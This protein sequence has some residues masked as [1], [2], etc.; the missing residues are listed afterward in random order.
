MKCLARKGANRLA[1]AIIPAGDPPKQP[2]GHGMPEMRLQAECVRHAWNTYPQ[3]RLLLF[4]VENEM[5]RPDANAVIGARRRA[6]GIVRGVA[7]LLL[8]KACRGYHGL[9]VEMKT[10]TGRQSEAQKEWQRAVEGQ[11]YL[12]RVCRSLDDFK[13]LL[14]WYLDRR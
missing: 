14:A 3:T 10:E 13:E 11:G 5:S 7:D 4:H 9:C 6:E 12:Y 8:L 1:R 2:K